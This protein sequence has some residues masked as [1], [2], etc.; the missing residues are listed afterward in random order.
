[1]AMRISGLMSGMDTE[2]IIQQLVEAKRTK[3]DDATKAQTRLSWK[4][5]IWKGL[6]SKL[7]NLQTKYLNNM[8]FSTAYSKKTTKVSNSSAV[9]VITGKDAVNSVQS[10][11]VEHLAKS[12]YLTGAKISG[13]GGEKLTALSKISDITS[14]VTGS[15]TINVTSGSTSV[16]ISITGETTISDV[17]TQIKKAGVHASFDATQQRFYISSQ[18]SGASND[19]SITA[20]D[21]QGAAALSA[22]GLATNLNSDPATLAQYKEYAAYYVTGDRDATL[23]NMQGKIDSAVNSRTNSYLE[24]Y[25]TL[26]SSQKTAQ[27]QLDALKEKYKDNPLDTAEAYGERLDAKNQEIQAKQE[28]LAG[29]TGAEAETAQDQLDALKAE[30]E[31][32][33]VLRADAQNKETQE[34]SLADINAKIAEVE[35]YVTITATSDANGEETYT[36]V[37]KDKLIGEEE[38]G[39]YNKAAYAAQVMAGYDPDDTTQTGATKVSGQDAVIYLNGVRYDN[40]DNVFEINGLTFT[41]LSETKGESVTITTQDDTEGIYDMLKDFLK[42]YNSIINEMDKLYNAPSAKGYEPLTSDEKETLTDSDIEEWETKIKDSLLRRDSNVST[43]SSALRGIMSSGFTV[44]GETMYL[45]D[46]GI[47]TLGYFESADNEKN[48]YHIDGDSDDANTSSKPDKLMG[49]ISNDP[50]TV[51]S[52]FSQL[53]ASLYD[54]MFEMSKSVEGYRSFGNFYDDKK[55]ASDYTDYTT[56]IAE[57]EKKLADYEDKWYAK[58]AAMETALAKMQKNASAVTGLLGGL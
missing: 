14:G 11:E 53:S 18:E 56:K 31:E 45:S 40:T 36:A 13:Q 8:R 55:M 19:F 6:N 44:N 47:S 32:L 41:A 15:G 39:F 22:L 50:D 12:G 17:L 3:V 26:K 29:L 1:M 28:E 34:A 57:L 7:K 51:I 2:S 43:I 10:L 46:F 35:S 5:D 23:A 16:D 20:S 4:Q 58:F 9:S 54:K 52:F 25:K 21:A 37:A 24:Q 27:D 33:R 30:A 49:M 48:A 38:D 42:E